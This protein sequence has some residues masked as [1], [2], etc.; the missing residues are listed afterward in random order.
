[1]LAY[2]TNSNTTS[3]KESHGY[4]FK[5]LDWSKKKGSVFDFNVSS[6]NDINKPKS[7]PLKFFKSPTKISSE[8][9][10]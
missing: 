8:K 10:K 9:T 5:F 4:I 7:H 2:K 3:E 6:D 1:M